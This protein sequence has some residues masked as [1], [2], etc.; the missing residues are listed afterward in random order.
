ML[1]EKPWGSEKLLERNESYMV[2]LLTMWKGQCCSIQY[3]EK[4]V[5]T[6]Y[7][8][9]GLLRVYIGDSLETL[10]PV[11]MKP[12]DHVTL[13]PGRVHRMEGVEDSTYLEASTPELEDVVRLQDKYGRAGGPT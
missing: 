6:V 11:D 9:S 5:E 4:K 3:H 8:L 2:K 7:V 10:A 13:R 12:G 1:I